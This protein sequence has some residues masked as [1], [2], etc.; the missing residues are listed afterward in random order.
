MG[1]ENGSASSVKIELIRGRYYAI[2]SREITLVRG[3]EDELVI[4]HRWG[5]K[6]FTS[7][8]QRQADY[9]PRHRHERDCNWGPRYPVNRERRRQR[10]F[11]ANQRSWWNRAS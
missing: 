3:C 11:S 10:I 4:S 9:V 6:H 8:Y 1:D 2:R 5:N 7:R